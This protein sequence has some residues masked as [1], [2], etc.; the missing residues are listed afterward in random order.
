[1]AQCPMETQYLLKFCQALINSELNK[2]ITQY[3]FE[4]LRKDHNKSNGTEILQVIDG[5]VS[6]DLC[7]RQHPGIIY[8]MSNMRMEVLEAT[9]KALKATRRTTN[10]GVRLE[11][12]RDKPT[13]KKHRGH[14]TKAKEPR[15]K[16][17]WK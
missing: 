1:M 4:E 16:E 17:E 15:E 6:N 11:G 9:G 5:M 2:S 8:S 10:T 14:P 13:S 12:Q 7:S 3:I